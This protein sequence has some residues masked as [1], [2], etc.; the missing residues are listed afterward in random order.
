MPPANVYMLLASNDTECIQCTECIEC[1]KRH[2]D[3]HICVTA[4][5]HTSRHTQHRCDLLCSVMMAFQVGNVCVHPAV[6]V[7]SLSHTKLVICICCNLQQAMRLAQTYAYT[8]QRC[9]PYCCHAAAEHASQNMLHWNVTKTWLS[10]CNACL[11][12]KLKL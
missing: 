2:E 4:T 7:C 10:I 9:P 3:G 5:E 8:R 6:Q 1:T 11:A 12:C